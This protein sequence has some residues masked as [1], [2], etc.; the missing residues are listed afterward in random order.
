MNEIT[1]WILLADGD[2]ETAQRES[3]VRV[4]P[5]YNAACFHA[6][7]SAEKYL[8]GSMI[9]QKV[10]FEKIHDLMKLSLQIQIKF[11]EFAMLQEWLGL[12]NQYPVAARYP[13][14]I[15]TREEAKDAIQAAKGVRDFVRPRV[16]LETK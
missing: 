5:N 10:P 13:G 6:H 2:L 16:N 8:K 1:E 7:Q 9:L 14:L 4:R 11:P 3:R 12:L 15:A